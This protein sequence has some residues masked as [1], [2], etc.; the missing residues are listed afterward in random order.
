MPTDP[1]PTTDE[2]LKLAMKAFRRKLRHL[3]AEDESGGGGRYGF[4]GRK[5]SIR[6]ITPPSEYPRE[7]WEELVKRGKLRKGDGLYELVEELK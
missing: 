3:I 2:V 7:I 4:G 6:G 1:T 5:S